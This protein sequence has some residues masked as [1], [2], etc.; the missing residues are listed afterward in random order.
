MKILSNFDTTLRKRSYKRYQNQYGK[1]SVVLL[2]K[3]KLFWLIK[4]FLPLLLF[5]ISMVLVFYA[6]YYFFGEKALQYVGLPFLG[7]AILGVSIPLFKNYIEYKMDFSIVTPKLFI[8]YDQKGVFRR[9][10]STINAENIRTISVV[11]E[12]IL[13]SLINNWD[14]IFLSDGAAEMDYWEIT[15]HYIYK[16]EKKRH[17]IA[18]ILRRV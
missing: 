4:F 6:L 1:E 2:A 13:Y 8:R 5:L 11:K 10:I 3:S 18:Q 15:L 14:L 16:S 7:F 17:M 12:G 9:R